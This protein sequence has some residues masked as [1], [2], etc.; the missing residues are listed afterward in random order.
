MG[1]FVS[2]IS[3]CA[4]SRM[5][6][7]VD[8]PHPNNFSAG[9]NVGKS[10]LT[11]AVDPSL[12]S[13]HRAPCSGAVG[14]ARCRLPRRRDSSRGN[15]PAWPSTYP[16]RRPTRRGARRRPPCLACRQ[17]RCRYRRYRCPSSR[18]GDGLRCGKCAASASPTRTH[19]P[20]NSAPARPALGTG[21]YAGFCSLLR[22]LCG[23]IGLL[24]LGASVCY[25]VLC[26]RRLGCEGSG[27]LLHPNVRSRA[28]FL[29]RLRNLQLLT[30]CTSGVS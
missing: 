5:H 1:S 11:P 9:S 28:F 3:D 17:A 22:L 6:A 19:R 25:R 7:S 4:Q 21:Q 20:R 30:S 27:G 29:C 12:D 2:F 18:R 23:F 14:T 8:T 15:F 24:F 26:F 16:P 10:C 13:V